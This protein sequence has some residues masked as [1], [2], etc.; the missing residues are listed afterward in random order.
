MHTLLSNP[1]IPVQDAKWERAPAGTILID[2]V[3]VAHTLQCC[4]CGCHFVSRKG[5]G[6]LRGFC[7]RCHK[8]TCG[9]VQCDTC[10]PVEEFLTHIE[11]GRS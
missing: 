9:A 7:M 6:M 11:R 5:S 3:E 10:I 4:H 8:I 2:G 1:L